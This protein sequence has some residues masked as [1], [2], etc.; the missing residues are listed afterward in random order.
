MLRATTVDLIYV[1]RAPQKKTNPRT[2]VSASSSSASRSWPDLPGFHTW[3]WCKYRHV[4]FLH[5][6]V[7]WKKMV[8]NDPET[9]KFGTFGR[10]YIKLFDVAIQHQKVPFHLICDAKLY[11]KK[12]SRAWASG[13]VICTIFAEM[14][15][16]TLTW[17]Q[18]SRALNKLQHQTGIER[19]DF[20]TRLKSL[21]HHEWWWHQSSKF[22]ESAGGC[23]G[24]NRQP[25]AWCDILTRDSNHWQNRYFVTVQSMVAMS[26][27]RNP[28]EIGVFETDTSWRA[29]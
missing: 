20:W 18:L 9:L 3:M 2:A 22:F 5:V 29:T 28:K 24:G 15:C 19:W 1:V 27:E 16:S 8:A 26:T 14:W 6:E 10:C 7:T 12:S 21:N 25:S 4:F 11:Q 13:P 17:T 23:R